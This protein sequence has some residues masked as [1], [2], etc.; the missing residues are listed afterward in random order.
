[1]G[2]PSWSCGIRVSWFAITGSVITVVNQTLP[3]Y[4]S[5]V[6]SHPPYVITQYCLKKKAFAL[7]QINAWVGVVV[8]TCFIN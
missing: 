7:I 4:T 3:N 6:Y 8:T 5:K 1:M 2:L